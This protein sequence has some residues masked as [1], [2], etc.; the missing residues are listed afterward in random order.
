MEDPKIQLFHTD[1]LE[2]ALRLV[3]EVVKDVTSRSDGT[4]KEE[5]A[6]QTEA[7]GRIVAAMI[8]KGEWALS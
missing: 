6:A 3:H 1:R 5:R 4:Y 2:E 7:T 8:M